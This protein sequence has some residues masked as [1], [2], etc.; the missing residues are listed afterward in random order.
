MNF[1]K[2]WL[3][4]CQAKEMKRRAGSI[5]E[6]FKVIEKDNKIWLTHMGFAFKE[7]P[8]N[9]SASEIAKELNNARQTAIRYEGYKLDETSKPEQQ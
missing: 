8:N 1:F 3:E 6:D 4:N 2:K 5:L 7:I 9:K